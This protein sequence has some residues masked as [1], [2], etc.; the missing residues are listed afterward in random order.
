M[1]ICHTKNKILTKKVLKA[2][3][4]VF[5]FLKKIK[6]KIKKIKGFFQKTKKKFSKYNLLIIRGFILTLF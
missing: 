3:K 4:K 6:E 1:T 2:P 5:V